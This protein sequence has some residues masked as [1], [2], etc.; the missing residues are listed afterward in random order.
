MKLLNL[1]WPFIIIIITLIVVPNI[2]N[3]QIV[4]NI[5]FKTANNKVYISYE[6]IGGSPFSKYNAEFYCSEDAGKTWGEPL[7]HFPKKA[8]KNI[9]GYGH[10]TAIWDVLKERE[11]LSGD[12]ICFKVVLTEINFISTTGTFIDNR[13]GNIY[14]WRN[15]G[16]N[17]W[18]TENLRY[19]SNGAVA[20]DFNQSKVGEMG[21]LYSYDLA[22]KS[23]P[24][25]WR[26]PKDSDWKKFESS[27]GIEKK[28]ISKFSWRGENSVVRLRDGEELDF[29][30][31]YSGMRTSSGKFK[32]GGNYLFLWS[33]TKSEKKTAYI[34]KLA[35][36]TKRHSSKIYRGKLSKEAKLS[37]RCIK[38]Q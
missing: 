14:K 18:M 29:H 22:K 19:K 23:C 28:E 35:N 25:G 36:T 10:N 27:L 31:T 33:F 20:Y 16:G 34:R 11:T 12:Q 15:I 5:E 2:G 37:V 4:Q 32:D 13:D 8:T 6:I 7:L 24:T 21:L 1:N 3:A 30:L 26:L 17:F 38:I 9:R